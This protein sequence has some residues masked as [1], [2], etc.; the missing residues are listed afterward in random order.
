MKDVFLCQN[1]KTQEMSVTKE[2]WQQICDNFKVETKQADRD[3]INEIV[4]YAKMKKGT[5]LRNLDKRKD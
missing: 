4:H 1:G 3:T 5:Q 2:T